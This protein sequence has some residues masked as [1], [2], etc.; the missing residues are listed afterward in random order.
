MKLRLLV[1]R[2]TVRQFE[3][4]ERLALV[5]V[6]PRGMRHLLSHC[7]RVDICYV[8][9]P[10]DTFSRFMGHSCVRPTTNKPRQD[11]GSAAVAV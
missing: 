8:C 1:Y 2:G 3:G 4:K 6:L 11:L 5:C 10:A 9:V 7:R